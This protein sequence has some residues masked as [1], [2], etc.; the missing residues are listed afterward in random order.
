MTQR[1][2]Q[3]QS[4]GAKCKYTFISCNVN[5]TSYFRL[6]GAGQ[7]LFKNW[8]KIQMESLWF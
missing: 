5:D 6:D 2:V 4:L 1:W 3:Q 7:T 8:R